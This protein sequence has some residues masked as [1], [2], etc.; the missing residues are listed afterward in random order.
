MAIAATTTKTTVQAPWFEIE[1]RAME[2]PSIPEPE[3]R[4]MSDGGETEKVSAC[5]ARI[6]RRHEQSQ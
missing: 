4:T 6:K 1:L 2:S 3:M 5:D